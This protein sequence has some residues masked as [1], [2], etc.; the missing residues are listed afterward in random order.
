MP[1]EHLKESPS[2]TAGPYVHIGTYPS[3]IGLEIRKDEPL[4]VLVDKSGRGQ[5]IRIEGIIYDGA[6]DPLRDAMVEIW[7]PDAD[8]RFNSP[9]FFGWGRAVANFDTGLF[10]FETIRPSPTPWRDGR[11]QAPHLQVLIFARGINIHLHTRMYFADEVNANE[12]DPVLALVPAARRRTLIAER[13]GD[14]ATY[15]F[16]IRL[17]GEDETVFFDV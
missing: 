17:Q 8:G 10:I 4:N 1:I 16:V 5:P 7:Q 9:D 2:Q 6:G 11:T 3:A 14:S 12:A 15:R 13:A